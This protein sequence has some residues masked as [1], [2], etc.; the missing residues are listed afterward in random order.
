MTKEGFAASNSERAC[1]SSDYREK[2]REANR[3]IRQLAPLLGKLRRIKPEVLLLERRRF[4]KNLGI[5]NTFSHL[6][7]VGCFQIDRRNLL[8]NAL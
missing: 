6:V 2:K 3:P 4:A 1:S 5:D 7:Q 8:N